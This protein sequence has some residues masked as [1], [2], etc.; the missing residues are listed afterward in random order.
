MNQTGVEQFISSILYDL[1]QWGKSKFHEWR[2]PGMYEVLNYES[3]LEIMNTSG[4]VAKFQKSEKIRFL[5]DNVIAVQDQVWGINNTIFGYKCSLGIPVDF[6][7]SGYKTYVLISLRGVRSKKD[8]VDINTQW[9]LRGEAI[10]KNGTWE[11]YINQC[12][13]K[14]N[15]SIIFP[16]ER[17]PL[18]AW[19]NERNKKKTFEIEKKS[20]TQLANN[21]WKITWEKRNPQMYETYAIDWEW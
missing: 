13:Q 7:Q 20:F 21:K 9:Y 8:E 11:T 12:T 2:K 16:A 10:G 4:T 14:I 18:K 17:P 5:Q 1:Y 15:L 19:V 3:T 6:Y